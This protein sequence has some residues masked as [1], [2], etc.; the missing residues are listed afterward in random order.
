M[1]ILVKKCV[2]L[3]VLFFIRNIAPTGGVTHEQRNLDTAATEFQRRFHISVD[4]TE[5]RQRTSVISQVSKLI[6]VYYFSSIFFR[7]ALSQLRTTSILN[8]TI[9]HKYNFD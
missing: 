4:D 5:S 7:M 9:L 6:Q 1:F 2:L 3:I 8:G